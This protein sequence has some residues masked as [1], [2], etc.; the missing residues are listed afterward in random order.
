MVLVERMLM[1]EQMVEEVGVAQQ[2]GLDVARKSALYFAHRY[3]G[4]TNKGTCPSSLTL[5]IA[6]ESCHPGRYFDL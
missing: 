1:K 2:D 5:L 3:T 4:L 6:C